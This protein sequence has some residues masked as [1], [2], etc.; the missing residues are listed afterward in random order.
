M[1]AAY[2]LL[3]VALALA[4]LIWWHR[5]LMK[6]RPGQASL[7]F[8]MV[9]HKDDYLM[10]VHGG[11]YWRAL[12]EVDQFCRT[13]IKHEGKLP[14]NEAGLEALERVRNIIR[15]HCDIGKIS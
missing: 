3:W 12:W 13:K 14:I 2:T 6:K 5:S 1:D 7:T 9:E 4:L 10:A 15:E 8:D 11:D